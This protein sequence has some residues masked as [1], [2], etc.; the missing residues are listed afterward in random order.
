MN[1]SSNPSAVD[2][3]DDDQAMHYGRVEDLE[4]FDK[5]FFE[6]TRT[7]VV[8]C[9]ICKMYI[10]T[11]D[12][13]RRHEESH[14]APVEELPDYSH[15]YR[16][17]REEQTELEEK[18]IRAEE[19]R[20]RAEEV[21]RIQ[22]LNDRFLKIYLEDPSR[23]QNLDL[24]DLKISIELRG[25]SIDVEQFDDLIGNSA[26]KTTHKSPVGSAQTDV[27]VVDC[28]ICGKKYISLERLRLHQT[29]FHGAAE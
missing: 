20:T 1:P 26:G 7:P 12:V 19:E 10:G 16:S 24:E 15:I 21:R 14:S 8:T 25:K 5:E 3:V 17:M 11:A 23:V 27:Y 6:A 18:R 13:I 2:E 28:S 4:I 22:A 9:C 29:M